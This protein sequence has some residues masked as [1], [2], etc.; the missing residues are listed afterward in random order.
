MKKLL[1]VTTQDVSLDV[2]IKGQLRYM[3]E[4]GFN[5]V[6]VAED[7]GRLN[8]VAIREGIRVIN[9]PMHR[10]I[11]IIADICSLYKLIR[12]F[13]HEQ[14]YIVHA[15]TPKA[16]LLSMFAAW[17]VR[18][19]VRIYTVTGLRFETAT[20][21][22]RRILKLMEMIT[23]KCAT[24]VIPEGNGVARTLVSE[25]ITLKPLAKIHNGNING[26]DLRYF[27]RT[28][29]V[30][31]RTVGIR[32]D[33]V[34]TFVFIGRMVRDKGINELIDAFCQLNDKYPNTRMLL[35][36]NLEENLDPIS[37]R[38]KTLI[39][40]NPSIEHVGYQND[41]RP[42]LASSDVLVLPSYREGFPNVILQA[43]AMG[44][45]VIVS[46]V[47]GADE[48]VISGYNGIIIPR[49]NTDALYSAMAEMV[50]KPDLRHTMSS[51]SRQVI[52]EK[53]NQEDIWNA[54]LER[55]NSYS[56]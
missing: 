7:T 34:T 15:N 39:D 4:H 10:D 28:Q 33:D 23:C 31:A 48:V 14:P 22:F 42:W 19:P 49:K 25:H 47:N 50:S 52:A 37:P 18:V 38:T 51:N 54:I 36:G 55:Y 56:V 5:V 43:G 11:S 6:G 45:P 17:I 46:D 32:K 40:S 53:F 20:G 9:I 2:L 26:I 13:H 27:D 8:S 12:L 29:D 44:L 21:N 30:M 3:N 35:V 24:D 41:V 16:S 1:R